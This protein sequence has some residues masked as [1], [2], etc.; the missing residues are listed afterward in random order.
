[1][2]PAGWALMLI[3]CGFVLCLVVFCY[4]RV[5]F[6][7]GSQEHLHAPLDLDTHDTEDNT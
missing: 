3:S 6:T 1:M 4:W 5:L 2:Q 7:P